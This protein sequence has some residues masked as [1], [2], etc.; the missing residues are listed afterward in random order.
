[1]KTAE[2]INS[3][4]LHHSTYLQSLT[5]GM[6]V[7]KEEA[8]SY[9]DSGLSC[10]TFNI[11]YITDG[12]KLKL[13]NVIS[14]FENKSYAFC[15]WI[16]EENLSEQVKNIFD[17]LN[18]REAG[19]EPG[20]SLELSSY[21]PIQPIGQIIKIEDT[22]RLEA[23][24]HIVSLNWN[25]ADLHIKEYYKR[26]CKTI[27]NKQHTVAYYGSCINDMLVSVIEVFPTDNEVA[28]LY[29][30]CTLE[31]YRGK[32]IATNLMKSCLN[33]LKQKGYNIATLQAADDGLDIY[34]KLEFIEQTRFYEYKKVMSNTINLW[35]AS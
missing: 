24:A 33:H 35:Y 19:N 5:D 13:E 31:K 10:D 18:L 2:K 20:M 9:S 14:H 4:F 17:V 29:N 30:L 25:P 27:F 8:F 22:E 7:G 34:K 21:Q 26:V 3:N 32:G 12:N 28:G 1:M 15:V 16:N 11:I 23:F 6:T